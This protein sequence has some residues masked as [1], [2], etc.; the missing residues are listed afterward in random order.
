MR[1]IAISNRSD[2]FAEE[3]GRQYIF[4]ISSSLFYI[5][6]V[7]ETNRILTIPIVT[8]SP[9]YLTSTINADEFSKLRIPEK[10]AFDI[11][12]VKFLRIHIIPAPN[13]VIGTGNIS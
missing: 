5:L 6:R 8:L 10:T 7:T 11:E 3:I 2:I 13:R 12:G 4:K 1:T 9:G